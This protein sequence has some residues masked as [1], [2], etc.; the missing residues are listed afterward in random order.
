[1]YNKFDVILTNKYFTL[2]S[3]KSLIL[4]ENNNIFLK[5]NSEKTC[6]YIKINKCYEN[7][8]IYVSLQGKLNNI[9]R[10]W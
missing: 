9:A 3:H 1:M 5:T 7:Y 10:K 2:L 8:R 4:F 6:L